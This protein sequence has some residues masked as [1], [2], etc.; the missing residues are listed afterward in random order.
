MARTRTDSAPDVDNYDGPTLTILGKNTLTPYEIRHAAKALTMK[1]KDFQMAATIM[2][3]GGSAS[4]SSP[5]CLVVQGRFCFPSALIPR[6][7]F[8]SVEIT[9]AM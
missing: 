7:V 9:T 1:A 2:M 3:A 8:I 6:A 4:R 5:P